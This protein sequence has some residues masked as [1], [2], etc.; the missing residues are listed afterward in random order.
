M[1]QLTIV[2]YENFD[3][4]VNLEL[5]GSNIILCTPNSALEFCKTT[6]R[7]HGVKAMPDEGLQRSLNHFF[8]GL[9]QCAV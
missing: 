1:F 9:Q 8:T 6:D 5:R 2:E 3:P 7:F 4:K